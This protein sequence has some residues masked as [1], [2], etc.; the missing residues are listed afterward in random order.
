MLSSAMRALACRLLGAERLL[1][2]AVADLAVLPDDAWEKT[3][4]TPLLVHFRIR[5]KERAT[6]Q[7][8]T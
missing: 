2:E 8:M 1:R 7:G 3:I 6:N 4:A 5:N